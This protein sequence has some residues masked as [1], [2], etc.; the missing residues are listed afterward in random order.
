MQQRSGYVAIVGEPNVGKSTLMNALLGQKISIVT[1]KPQTTRQRVLGIL[2]TGEAQIVFLDTPGLLRPKYLLHEKMV[3]AAQRALEDADIV[4]VM[5][6]P[7][8]GADLPEPVAKLVLTRYGY[9]PLILCI[10]K[11][12][13]VFKDSLLPL[14]DAFAKGNVFREIVPVSALKHQNLD[15]LL[16]TLISYLPE[17]PALYP[18]DIVSDQTE[19]FFVAE[20]IREKIFD[21]FQEEIPYSTAV[22]INEFKE[23]EE[24][25][26]YIQATVVVERDSQKGILVGRRGA[27]LKKVGTSARAAI[28]EFVG[29]SVY[30]ELRVKVGEKWR[31]KEAWMRRLGYQ[32]HELTKA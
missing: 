10:N 27:A 4:L 31:D 21:Q 6:E 5:T 28:E 30:L 14:I 20:L 24:G 12:D 26:T 8:S 1:R 9:K 7:R 25:K 32:P 29:K 16:K 3:S 17:H 23:R 2:T 18:D 19:R 22:E 13:T 11:A 15:D